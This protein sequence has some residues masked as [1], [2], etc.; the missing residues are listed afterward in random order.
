MKVSCEPVQ[1]RYHQL[2]PCGLGV[3]DG[4]LQLGAGVALA[5]L[6]FNVF[7]HELPAAPVEIPGYC[8]SL[9]FEA[10]ATAALFVG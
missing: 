8:V 10:K 4:C 1:S 2:G 9:S 5:A 6:H 3:T 7:G